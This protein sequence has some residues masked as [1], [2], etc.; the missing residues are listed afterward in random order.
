V[1]GREPSGANFDCV[2]RRFLAFASCIDQ[3]VARADFL[4]PRL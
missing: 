1:S 4:R 3:R 2:G